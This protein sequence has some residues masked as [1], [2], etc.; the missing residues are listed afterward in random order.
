[1]LNIHC[2]L[3]TENGTILDISTPPLWSVLCRILVAGLN[4]RYSPQLTSPYGIRLSTMTM[5]YRFVTNL[6]TMLG[7]LA[8]IMFAINYDNLL[9]VCTQ[10]EDKMQPIVILSSLLTLLFEPISFSSLI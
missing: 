6:V 7:T 9:L 8:N 5:F 1:M 4:N 3:F 10:F 2:L